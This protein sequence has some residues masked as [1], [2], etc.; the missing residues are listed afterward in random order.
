MCQSV[1]R[2]NWN[3]TATSGER[4]N[5]HNLGAEWKRVNLGA[6][7]R[8]VLTA[9]FLMADVPTRPL[10]DD[11]SEELFAGYLI[12]GCGSDMGGHKVSE[13]LAQRVAGRG[14]KVVDP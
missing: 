5:P 4:C 11:C 2:T 8:S 6:D 9:A 3:T 14:V 1:G 10:H 12:G 13:L 7:F